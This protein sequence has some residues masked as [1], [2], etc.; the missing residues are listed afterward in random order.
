MP[1]ACPRQLGADRKAICARAS[2][3]PTYWEFHLKGRKA[4]LSAV[5]SDQRWPLLSSAAPLR[6]YQKD[7]EFRKT[8]I[9]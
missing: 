1:D 9:S 6:L 5:T 3:P 7:S 2:Y 8:F 4:G